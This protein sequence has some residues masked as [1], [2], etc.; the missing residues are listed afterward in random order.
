LISKNPED[1]FA[2]VP[3]IYARKKAL[4]PLW[5]ENTDTVFCVVSWTQAGWEQYSQA[6]FPQCLF[7]GM[8]VDW[9]SMNVLN[10][11]YRQDT[12]RAG[13]FWKARTANSFGLLLR[14]STQGV[15]QMPAAGPFL[16][17]RHEHRAVQLPAL[18]RYELAASALRLSGSL[19]TTEGTGT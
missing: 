9:D 13:F 2:V 6:D 1:P 16:C 10:G 15:L 17:P 3:F 7:L 8:T 14:S 4:P 5:V 12:H 19:K 11:C 18:G